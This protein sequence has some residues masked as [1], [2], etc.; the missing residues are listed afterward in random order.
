MDYKVLAAALLNLVGGRGNV[1]TLT[2]C[3]TR[4]RFSLYDNSQANKAEIQN[5]EG[6]LSVVVSG[7]QLQVVIGNKVAHVYKE[8][9][10]LLHNLEAGNVENAVPGDKGKENHK[11]DNV[12]MMS[13]VFDIISGS[14]SPLIGVMAGSGILKAILVILTMSDMLSEQSST[15]LILSAI[16]NAVFYFLPVLLGVSAA[17]KMGANAY[18]GGTI[19]AAIMEPNFTGLIGNATADFIGIPVM[20]ISYASSVFPIFIAVFF[21]SYLE[22]FLRKTCPD[23]IQMFMVPMLLLV[24]IVP[25]TVLIFGPF[26]VYLGEGIAKIFNWLISFNGILTGAFIGGSM[27]FL[28]VLGLHWALVPIIISNVG[29]GGD[30]LVGMWAACSFAQMGVALALWF[31]VHDKNVRTIAGSAVIS[32]LLAGVTEP[33]IYGL[34]LKY[35]KTIPIVVISGA[36]GGAFAG[37]YKVKMIA[38][39][40]HSIPSIPLFH[41]VGLYLISIVLGFALAFLLT[42]MFS[43]EALTGNKAQGSVI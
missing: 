26:G 41:P 40:F 8:L 33:I 28:V 23:N 30:P 5:I 3:A 14:L 20:A 35:R 43:E 42:I 24:F 7:G 21:L 38:M 12:S 1:D 9:D 18:I 22:R 15:Y 39:G 16:S 36:I 19:G 11:K 13:K 17:I 27:M 4:L 34:I 25:L 6:V 31:R 10:I 32:G 37:Y 29:L 2:H